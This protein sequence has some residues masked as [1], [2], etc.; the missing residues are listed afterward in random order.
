MAAACGT[1]VVNDAGARLG[2]RRRLRG[3]RAYGVRRRAYSIERATCAPAVVLAGESLL[4]SVEAAEGAAEAPVTQLPA[5]AEAS[6][7]TLVERKPRQVES[8]NLGGGTPRGERG[9]R[10]GKAG[11]PGAHRG[12]GRAPWRPRWAARVLR[13]RRELDGARALHRRVRCHAEAR[14]VRGRGRFGAGAAHGGATGAKTI[15]AINK[16]K[17]APVFKQADYGIVGDLYEVVPQLVESL[18]AGK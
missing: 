10:P 14:P 9:P 8:V 13:R 1:R 4:M 7:I 6:G 5:S 2:G 15:V 3:S 17:N 16:D 18:K 11:G 12:A